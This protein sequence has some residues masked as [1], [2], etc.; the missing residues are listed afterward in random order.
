MAEKNNLSEAAIK[1]CRPGGCGMNTAMETKT[2]AVEEAA[3]LYENSIC[4]KIEFVVDV[5]KEAGLSQS[6]FE[7]SEN[8]FYLIL[9]DIQKKF[10]P[11]GALSQRYS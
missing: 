6:A 1:G 10:L 5:V 11:L 4:F 3:S 9:E 8:G 2:L 7:M